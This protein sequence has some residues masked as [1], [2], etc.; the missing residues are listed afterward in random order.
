MMNFLSQMEQETGINFHTDRELMRNLYNHLEAM[1][2]R[3][4]GNVPIYKPLHQSL[5][6]NT[7]RCTIISKS[8]LKK[9]V[10][11]MG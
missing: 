9:L 6:R 8:V 2:I 3:I 7:R 10:V 1:L 4:K 5:R 11:G